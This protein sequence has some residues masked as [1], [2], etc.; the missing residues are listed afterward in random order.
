MI[1]SLIT[2]FVLLVVILTFQTIA[3]ESSIQVANADT[4]DLNPNGSS[5][6]SKLMREMQKF[7]GEAK[8]TLISETAPASFP[9][10]LDKIYTAKISEGV[11]KSEFY[12]QFADLYVMSVKNYASSNSEN[13]IETYNNMVNACLACHSQH[14]PGPV[15]TI[16]KMMVGVK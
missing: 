16:K 5:E 12:K 9:T 13:R 6:L 3:P 15:P 4:T 11:N 7:T 14:C 2:L 8:K 10:S 1:K